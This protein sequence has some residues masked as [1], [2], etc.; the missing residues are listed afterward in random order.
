MICSVSADLRRYEKQQEADI[1]YAE[2]LE[3]RTLALLKTP[4]FDPET[5]VNISQASFEL[6]TSDQSEIFEYWFER[7]EDQAADD[8]TPDPDYFRD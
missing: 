6:A 7:A 4:A 2:E 3:R 1:E 5:L 8:M